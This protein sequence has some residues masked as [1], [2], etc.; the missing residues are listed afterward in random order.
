MSLKDAIVNVADSMANAVINVLVKMAS[1]WIVS[2][3]V[4]MTATK[5]AAISESSANIAIAATGAAASQAAIPIVGP[6]LAMGAAASMAT[7]LT[8]FIGPLLSA[9]NGFD[10]PAGLNPR[11][12]LHEQEMVL[13]AKYANP[14]RKM[15]TGGGLGGG[16]GDNYQVQITA[17]DAHGLEDMLNRNFTALTKVVRKQARDGRPLL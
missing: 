6:G 16:G 12:Q 5:A 4:E 8:A 10:I 3:L 1:Q 2:K 15:L 13:P 14:L 7:F 11:V 9:A 17:V